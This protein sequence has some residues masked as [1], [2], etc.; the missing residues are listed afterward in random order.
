TTSLEPHDAELVGLS[1]CWQAGEAYYVALRGPEGEA[2]L[3]TGRVLA[4]LK[5]LLEAE[6]PAKINQNIK[7]DSQVLRQQGIR[8]AGVQGDPMLAHYLLHANRP[9]HSIEVLARD[10]LD[11]TVI[12][13]TDL[14]GAKGKKQLRM[15][16]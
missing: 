2:V 8:L 13:I 9:G 1:F 3:D 5:P 11:H 16:Q 14:I 10:I 6:A 7:Y 4:A 15:D 12:P